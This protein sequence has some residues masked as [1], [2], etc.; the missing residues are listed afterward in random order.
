MHNLIS[1]ALSTHIFIQAARGSEWRKGHKICRIKVINFPLS[2]IFHIIDKIDTYITAKLLLI[3]HATIPWTGHSSFIRLHSSPSSSTPIMSSKSQRGIPSKNESFKSSAQTFFLSDLSTVNSSSV[4][5]E[6]FSA[7]LILLSFNL[8]PMNT[9]S[10]LRSPKW[11][12][13]LPPSF[14]SAR[15]GS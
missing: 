2:K 11:V 15:Y 12:F 13:H 1:C 3:Q 5:R 7:C 4:R 8:I 14:N 6:S 9:I 10:D